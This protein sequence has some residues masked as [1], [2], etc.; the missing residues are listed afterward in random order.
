M[1][2]TQNKEELIYS[3]DATPN[4][5]TAILGKLEGVCADTINPTRNGRRYSEKLWETV[6]NDTII[7]ELFNAGGIF[8]EL[9]HPDREEVDISKVAICMPEPPK[10]NKN[11]QLVGHW[12]ILNTPC[13]KILKVLCDYGYKMGISTRGSGDTFTDSDGNESV[14]PETY[15]LTAMDIV[16]VPAVKAA[17]LDLVTE[18]LDTKSLKFKKALNEEIEKSSETDKKVMIEALNSL[19][20]NYTTNTGV[21][22]IDSNQTMDAANNVGATVMLEWKKA[23]KENKKLQEQVENLQNQLSV[24]YTKENDTNVN[25]QKLS[26]EHNRIQGELDTTKSLLESANTQIKDL[27]E[28]CDSYFH[29]AEALAK[30]LTKKESECANLTEEHNSILKKYDTLNEQYQEEKKDFVIKQT[31]FNNELNKQKQLTEKYKLVAKTAIDRYILLQSKMLNVSPNEIKN[32]LSENYSFKDIDRICESFKDKKINFNSIP[33]SHN[34]QVKV[35]KSE[36][37][38][39]KYEDSTLDDEVDTSLLNCIK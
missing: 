28:K 39:F 24:C 11:G 36:E 23:I 31:E 9:G 20:I 3:V 33:I 13:G 4:S 8:G 27:N 16:L 14:D 2:Q 12:D 15:Q 30:A 17:R 10:K 26:A 35:T 18:S 25:N 38:L 7:K 37:P 5:D 6:F 29:D 19:N 32:K 34:T 1:A 21:S 22:N